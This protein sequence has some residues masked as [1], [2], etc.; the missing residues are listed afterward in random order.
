MIM[1]IMRNAAGCSLLFVAAFCP[2]QA[3]APVPATPI[4]TYHSE[5]MSL[6]F[7]YPSSFGNKSADDAAPAKDS[8]K[9]MIG[10]K[11][12]ISLPITATDMRNGFNMIFLRRTDGACLGRDI[13]AAERSRAAVSFL[14]DLLE[15][16]GKP[17][18]NSSTDYDI[19]SHM[20]SAVSGAVK[21]EHIKPAGTVIYG[22]GTCVATGKDLACFAFLSSDCKALAALSAS[23]VKFKDSAAIPVIPASL[24]PV[25]KSAS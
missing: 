14:R 22:S 24:A 21:L 11:S 6:E 8:D 19:A 1:T 10:K 18:V 4:S 3:P 9:G 2:G 7:A 20:A 5:A 15:Q 17:D 25:C 13:T 16:F 23:T 12:C